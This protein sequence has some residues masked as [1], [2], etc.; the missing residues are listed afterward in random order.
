[1]I[2]VKCVCIKVRMN[3]FYPL[4]SC[5][6]QPLSVAVRVRLYLC[7]YVF[8]FDVYLLCAHSIEGVCYRSAESFF[9][10]DFYRHSS[11]CPS[12]SLSALGSFSTCPSCFLAMK[13]SS[14][15]FVS[16]LNF[17]LF[18]L[19][20]YLS[21]CAVNLW[22]NE[23]KWKCIRAFLYRSSLITLLVSL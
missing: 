18:F 8:I 3:E 4:N 9:Y 5:E 22:M 6:T 13:P 7:L 21:L 1:M 20:F 10:D 11:L 2:Y 23:M 12:F 17:Y 15:F 14:F 19:L 16:P